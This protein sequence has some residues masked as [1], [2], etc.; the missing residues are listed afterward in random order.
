MSRNTVELRVAT[1]Y[2]K[3]FDSLFKKENYF[4]THAAG[5]IRLRWRK[6][7]KYQRDLHL[8]IRLKL[9]NYWLK[10]LIYFLIQKKF[11]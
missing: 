7:G 3:P 9:G 10:K 1:F 2:L 11:C 8:M 5:F 4:Q 6:T